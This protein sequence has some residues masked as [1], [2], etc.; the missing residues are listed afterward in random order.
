MMSSSQFGK[1]IEYDN[2]RQMCPG[3][4][5]KKMGSGMYVKRLA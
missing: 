5:W 1:E 3:G 2:G 4:E